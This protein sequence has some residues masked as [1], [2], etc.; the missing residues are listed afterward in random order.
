M[1][2]YEFELMGRIRDRG[3]RREDLVGFVRWLL[4]RKMEAGSDCSDRKS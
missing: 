2:R 3:V 4:S 1:R